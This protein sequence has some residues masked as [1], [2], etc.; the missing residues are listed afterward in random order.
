MFHC[1]G[2]EGTLSL[3]LHCIK[4]RVR[5]SANRNEDEA[6]SHHRGQ[7]RGLQKHQ[8]HRPLGLPH[9]RPPDELLQQRAGDPVGKHAEGG[10]GA[11][12]PGLGALGEGE[13]LPR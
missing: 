11:D 6:S 2:L 13:D 1:P 9:L 5:S 4:V 10:G 3:T 8:H 7:S 12:Q